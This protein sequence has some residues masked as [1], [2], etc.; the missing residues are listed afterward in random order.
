VAIPAIP[1]NLRLMLI[2][3][4]EEWN[5]GPAD[6]GVAM[7]IGGDDRVAADS[8]APPPPIVE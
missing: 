4:E 2:S 8:A 7:D 6:S 3:N 5:S 1:S